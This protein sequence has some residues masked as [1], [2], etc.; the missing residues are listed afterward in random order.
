MFKSTLFLNHKF[1]AFIITILLFSG[2]FFFFGWWTDAYQHFYDTVVSG[3]LTDYYLPAANDPFPEYMVGAAWFFVRLGQLYPIHWI[4]FFLQSVLFISIWIIFYQILKHISSFPLVS[5]AL[6]ILFFS[7]LFAESIILYHM[8]RITMFAGIAAISVL[9]V[10]DEKRYVSLKT[11][12]YLALFTLALWIRCNVH[13]FILVF[14]SIA[15]LLHGKSLKPLVPFYLCFSLFF[16]YYCKVVL[17]T[18]CSNDLNFYFLY[19]SE[20]KLYYVGNYVPKL[21]LINHLDSLKYS[22]IKMDILG[23]EENLSPKFYEQIGIFTNHSRFSLSQTIYALNTFLFAM[24]QNV[25]FVIADVFLIVFYVFLGGKKIK[26]YKIKTLL[27]FSFFYLIVF[28]ISFLK[29]ENRFLVPFQVLF[30]FTIII[31]HRPNLFSTNR[32]QFW[33]LLFLALIIPTS[34]FYIKQKVDFEKEENRVFEKTFEYLGKEFSDNV[35]VYNTGFVTKNKPYETFYQR[36]YFKKFYSYNYF[37]TQ[38]SQW[39]RPY[40]EKECNCKLSQL[41]TFYEYLRIQEY[42]VLLLD[43]NDRIKLLENYLLEVNNLPQQ[44]KEVSVPKNIKQF[45]KTQSFRQELNV[46]RLSKGSL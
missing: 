12:P 2:C 22:A 34:V 8:V 32:Y 10:N 41:G 39:Y 6:I 14:I 45:L 46:Y 44:F 16:L 26:N 30:L 20:F 18:D 29:M 1:Q 17:W 13:L 21:N 42:P 33:F 19:H 25:Y 35:L 43:R 38:L 15:F 37:A 31:L 23:D 4:A 9:I 27:L 11:L 5:R 36:K 40:L 7:L 24:K 3:E 28:A